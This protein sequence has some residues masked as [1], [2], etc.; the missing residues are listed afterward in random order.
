MEQISLAVSCKTRTEMF[1]ML[2]SQRRFWVRR[3][4]LP[5]VL[6]YYSTAF[7]ICQSGRRDFSFRVDIE[8]AVCYNPIYLI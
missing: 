7:S 6:G 4:L 3:R 1:S 5:Y 2:A 8:E